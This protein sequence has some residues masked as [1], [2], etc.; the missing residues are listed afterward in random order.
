MLTLESQAKGP[1]GKK[2]SLAPGC[3]DQGIVIFDPAG[4]QIVNGRLMLTARKGH[5]TDLDVAAG[6]KLE[7]RSEGRQKSDFEEA[8][9]MNRREQPF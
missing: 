4:W 9:K 6:R 3:R 2:A 7:K 1:G 5:K 8:M